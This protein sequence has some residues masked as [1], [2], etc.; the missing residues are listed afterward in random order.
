M[1]FYK[2]ALKGQFPGAVSDLTVGKSTRKDVF[3]A[4]GDPR[5]NVI[6]YD[7]YNANM[8]RP[9]YATPINPIKFARFE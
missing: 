6:G 7:V 1:S 8:G 3:K 5:K 2:P 9:G 4:I